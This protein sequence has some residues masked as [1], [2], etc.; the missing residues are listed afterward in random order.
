MCLQVLMRFDSGPQ[1]RK[2][3]ANILADHYKIEDVAFSM[4]V[5]DEA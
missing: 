3:L 2:H 5:D 4:Q 1:T